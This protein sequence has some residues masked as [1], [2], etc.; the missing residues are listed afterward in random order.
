M[1]APASVSG[2]EN[3]PQRTSGQSWDRFQNNNVSSSNPS[4]ALVSPRGPNQ[5]QVNQY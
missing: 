1:Y 5:A 4:K 2:Y 3:A